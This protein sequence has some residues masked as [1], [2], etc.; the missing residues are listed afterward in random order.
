MPAETRDLCAAFGIA[1]LLDKR[2]GGLNSIETQAAIVVREMQKNPRVLLMN[3]PESFLGH[4]KFDFLVKFFDQWSAD[5]HP[6]VFFSFDRRLI[7][8]YANR[9]IVIENGSL[10]K[11]DTKQSNGQTPAAG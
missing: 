7:R 8:R 1:D 10:S 2:A 6:V 3:Q 9:K 5:R 11:T 4:S